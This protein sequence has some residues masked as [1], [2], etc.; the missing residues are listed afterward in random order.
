MWPGPPTAGIASMRDLMRRALEK[1][2]FPVADAENGRAALAEIGRQTPVL[3]LLDL[4]MPDMHGFEFLAELRGH[5]DWRRIPVIIVTGKELPDA[6]RERLSG[7]VQRIVQKGSSGRGSLV[8]EI[9]D[10]VA[11]C[12]R[13]ESPEEA[14]RP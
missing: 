14:R 13:A 7:Q 10:M 5:D 1:E 11:A 8:Q 3:I 12:L 4:M 6:D 2:G 9:R